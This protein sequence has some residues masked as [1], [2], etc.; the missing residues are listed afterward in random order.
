MLS[1]SV[2]P[3]A[4]SE[5]K[6]SL[7]FSIRTLKAHHKDIKG[8]SKNGLFLAPKH[9]LPKTTCI[10]MD[11]C[12]G[13]HHSQQRGRPQSGTAHRRSL[14]GECRI[15]KVEA[16]FATFRDPGRHWLPAAHRAQR[17]GHP[18]TSLQ[19]SAAHTLILARATPVRLLT[20]RTARQ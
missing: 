7:C 20:C 11:L 19:L 12:V 18:D 4:A 9:Y 10:S 6:G 15:L 5:L 8:S 1:S 16:W 13:G 2:L 14:R 3:T 17:Q